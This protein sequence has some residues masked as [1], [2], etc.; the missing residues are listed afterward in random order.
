VLPGVR[1]RS[2]AKKGPRLPQTLQGELGIGAAGKGGSRKPHAASRK[3]VRPLALCVRG[4]VEDQA[5]GCKHERQVMYD[6]TD[7]PN[8]RCSTD[9]QLTSLCCPQMRKQARLAK[10]QKKTG[11]RSRADMEVR[12]TDVRSIRVIAI[13]HVPLLSVYHDRTRRRRKP[14][15]SGPG[16]RAPPRD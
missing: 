8:E 7:G 10:K 6:A 9:T 1:C 12:P 14:L 16:S 2:Q 3:E 13:H 15:T 11:K 5:E 4:S